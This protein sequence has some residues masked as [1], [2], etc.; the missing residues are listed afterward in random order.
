[1]VIN[2]PHM[3][4]PP[5]SKGIYRPNALKTVEQQV[6]VNPGVFFSVDFHSVTHIVGD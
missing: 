5:F 4:A 3:I 1:M 2:V 6:M